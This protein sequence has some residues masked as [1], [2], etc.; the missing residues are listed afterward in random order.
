MNKPK[1]GE[2]QQ[3]E[4]DKANKENRQP[5]C[6]SCEKPLD[7]IEET[8]DV[9]LHWDWDDKKKKYIKG[10]DDGCSNK[11]Y[12]AKCETKDWDFTNNGYVNY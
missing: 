9:D 11:P 5:Y 12:C 3:E 10:E 4:F 7:R 6:I 2:T 8:Q 1:L